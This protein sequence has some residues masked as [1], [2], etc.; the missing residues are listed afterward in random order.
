MVSRK[1]VGSLVCLSVVITLIWITVGNGKVH[2]L[3]YYLPCPE[4]FSMKLQYTEEKPIQLFPHGYFFL[5]ADYFISSQEYWPQS[6][7]M[8]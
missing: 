6:V 3:P 4:I 2:Y 5:F 1:V 7:R 8:C